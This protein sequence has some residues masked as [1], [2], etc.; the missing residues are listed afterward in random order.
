MK[1]QMLELY[2]K[3]QNLRDCEAGQDLVEYSMVFAMVALGAM[4]GMKSLD[5]A[6]IQAFSTVSFTINSALTPAS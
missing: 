4:V 2:L 1:D 6:I 5:S 3:L